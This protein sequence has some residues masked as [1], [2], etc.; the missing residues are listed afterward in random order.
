MW[1]I[2]GIPFTFEELPQAMA[3]LGEI[4][5]EAEDVTSYS[6]DEMYRWSEY[7]IAEECHPLLFPI[8]EFIENYEE[9]PE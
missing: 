1:Y 9:V 5:E 2:Q 4:Q 7:L 6:M 3:E 8:D